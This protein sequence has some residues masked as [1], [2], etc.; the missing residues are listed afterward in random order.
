VGFPV[1]ECS[2]SSGLNVN[3]MFMDLGTAILLNNREQLTKVESEMNGHTGNSIILAEFA[4]RQKKEKK[5]GS[6]CKS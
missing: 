1:Y 3:S 6:C 4:E 2:A 5:K